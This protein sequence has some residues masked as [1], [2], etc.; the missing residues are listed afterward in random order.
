MGDENER[1]GVGERGGGR[2]MMG[3]RRSFLNLHL[4]G[5]SGHISVLIGYDLHIFG[6]E[7][8]LKFFFLNLTKPTSSSQHVTQTCMKILCHSSRLEALQK[9]C[10][11]I[12]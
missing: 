5:R 8:T 7:W 1:A 10:F 2:G 4:C 11:Q 3:T 6:F 9:M 12:L